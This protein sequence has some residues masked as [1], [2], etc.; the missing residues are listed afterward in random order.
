M[1]LEHEIAGSRYLYGADFGLT[2][3]GFPYQSY[4]TTWDVDTYNAY[5]SDQGQPWYNETSFDPL[6][7]YDPVSGG[8]APYPIQKTGSAPYLL[9]AATDSASAATAMATGVKTDSGNISWRRNDPTVGA[10]E[11]IAQMMRS[12]G[13]AAIGVVSSVPF[14]H[15]TPAAFVSHNIDRNN[16]DQIA[17]EI[18]HIARPEVV[19]GGGHPGWSGYITWQQ[20]DT[21]RSSPDYVLVERVAGQNGGAALLDAANSI[22]ADKKLFGLFGG[23]AGNFDAPVPQDN[24]GN[25]GFTVENENPSLMDATNAALTVL[26]RNRNGFFLM[27]EQGDIDWANHANNYSMMIGCMWNMENAVKAAAA[28]VDTPGD[29][30]DWSNTLLVITA[31]HANSY[32]RL[33]DSP[34]LGAGDLPEQVGSS[35]PC[36]EVTYGSSGH[37]NELVTIYAKGKDA[38]LFY[39]FEGDWYS[40]T[41]IIDNTHIFMVMAKAAGLFH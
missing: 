23:S 24:P 6:L 27:V 30:I 37:T 9:R 26:S 29:D 10:I 33:T 18:I 3:H 21:I 32:M 22:A 7:G 34:K 38:S 31:D 8:A 19:I 36:G 16:Y 12:N 39:D 25:P 28:F 14:N 20:L 4:V 35:Y 40:A 5:A 11:T 1:Q 17:D 15:A 41:R 2:W 13:G